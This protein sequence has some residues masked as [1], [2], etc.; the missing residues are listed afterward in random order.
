MIQH[1]MSCSIQKHY[2]QLKGIQP[3]MKFA[4]LSKQTIT[5]AGRLNI[6]VFF[7]CQAAA[8]WPQL[9]NSTIV[10]LLRPSTGKIFQ[11]SDKATPLVGNT[12]VQQLT[13]QDTLRN[14]WDSTT[15]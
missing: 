3:K 14:S 6:E 15:R 8:R 5:K 7:S 12:R 4:G 1:Q 2:D 9:Q 13:G 11:L 10:L